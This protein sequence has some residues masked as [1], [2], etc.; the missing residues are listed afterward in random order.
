[1]PVFD[2][3]CASMGENNKERNRINRTA[4]IQSNSPATGLTVNFEAT[5]TRE[6][7]RAKQA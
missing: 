4:V 7:G 1:M 5:A 2:I 3:A 6:K